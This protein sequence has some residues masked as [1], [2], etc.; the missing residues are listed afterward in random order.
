[1]KL[2]FEV[3]VIAQGF[4]ISLAVVLA[5]SVN[6]L[7]AEPM[8]FRE[9][10]V[11]GVCAGCTWFAAEGDITSDTPAAFREAFG[12]PTGGEGGPTIVINSDGGDNLA[13]A[14]ELGRLFRA[15]SVRVRIG[16]TVS[17]P[18]NGSFVS[19]IEPGKCLSACAYAF[20]E[21][22]SKVYET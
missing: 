14:L 22:D 19:K 8:K 13:A 9:A 15:H 17:E 20:L 4:F 16:D 2:L 12:E 10:T 18:Q 6:Q 21:P 5:A 11:G 3:I 7:S 1:M